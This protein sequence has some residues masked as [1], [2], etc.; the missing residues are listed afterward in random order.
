MGGLCPPI[1]FYCRRGSC[2]RSCDGNDVWLASCIFMDHSRRY[3]LWSRSGFCF[4]L[5]FCKIRWEINRPAYWNIY[6]KD[7]KKVIFLILLVIYIIG[8]CGFRRYGCGNFSWFSRWRLQITTKCCGC[9]H[10]YSLCFCGDCI[11]IILTQNENRRLETSCFR[12][13][14]NCRYACSRNCFSCLSAKAKLVI[15][16]VCL[17]FLRKC[18]PYVALKTTA[19]LF[20]YLLICRN[21]HCSC[22]RS[23]DFKSYDFNTSLHRFC[24][25]EW[26]LFISDTVCHHCLRCSKRI[27]FFSIKR[28]EQQTDSKWKRH[29]ASGL[30]Q[31]ASGISVSCIS[32]CNCRLFDKFSR[33]R[34]IK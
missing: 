29:A 15:F 12:N 11:W 2:H 34:C 25:C 1:F 18:H 4:P 24:L 10:F 26:K 19:W 33:H 14:T 13:R 22:H 31:Y 27:P 5:Y 6:W 16:S 32:N 28:D 8:H 3:F 17:Y 23:C 9:F 20:D 7:R 21:D 30:R